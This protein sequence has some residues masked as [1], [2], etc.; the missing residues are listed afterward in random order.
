MMQGRGEGAWA[1]NGC[2]MAINSSL[3]VKDLEPEKT[4]FGGNR[5]QRSS[6]HLYK[7]PG[8]ISPFGNCI[9]LKINEERKK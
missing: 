9:G 3:V 2:L 8:T 6:Q 4:K 7:E 1:G 5:K